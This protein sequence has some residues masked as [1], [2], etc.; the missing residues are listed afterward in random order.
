MAKKTQQEIDEIADAPMCSDVSMFMCGKC[1][2]LHVVFF[3]EHDKPMGQFSVDRDWL[4]AFFSEGMSALGYEFVAA[5]V[6]LD[7]TGTPP[8]DSKH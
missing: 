3:D 6:N 4:T 5:T 1:S 7:P 8:T 2:H